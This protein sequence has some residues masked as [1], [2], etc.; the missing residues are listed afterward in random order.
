MGDGWPR[1]L[2]A[3]AAIDATTT[4]RRWRRRACRSSGRRRHGAAAV[5]RHRRGR[6]RRP[7]PGR[8]GP[9]VTRPSRTSCNVW[10]PAGADLRGGSVVREL[11]SGDD[12]VELVVERTALGLRRHRSRARRHRG[13]GGRRLVERTPAQPRGRP[14]VDGAPGAGHLLRRRGP[15][16][17]RDGTAPGVDLDGRA[18]LLRV[19]RFGGRASRSRRI[20]AAPRSRRRPAAS[21]PTPPSSPART[22][23]PAGSS[24]AGWARRRT[25]PCLYTLTPIVTSCSTA[26]PGTR[27]SSWHRARTGSSSW[28]GSAGRSALAAGASVEDDLSPSRSTGLRSARRERRAGWCERGR[29]V[30]FRRMT[31]DPAETRVRDHL[32]RLGTD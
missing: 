2:S 23:S 25:R 29:A 26:C 32:A 18:E 24:A 27:E 28:P 17:V 30:R 22:I 1:P 16:T 10:P 9:G 15:G 7:R 4:R 20:A 3:R 19:P 14:A 31:V 11:R 13:G 8:D 21:S 6:R 5:A 12:H